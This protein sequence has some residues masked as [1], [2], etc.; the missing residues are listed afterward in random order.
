MVELRKKILT[1]GDSFSLED[2]IKEANT[3]ETVN[4]QLEEFT[5]RKP[6][7]EIN[8]LE[9]KKVLRGSCSRCGSDKHTSDKKCPARNIKCI[10]CGYIGHFREQCRTTK[11]RK[12]HKEN[13]ENKEQ[14]AKRGSSNKKDN[15]EDKE[16]ID[17]IFHIDDDEII[18][19]TIGGV[20]TTML[21]DSG[22]KY[23]LLTDNTW[24]RLKKERIVVSNQEKNPKRIFMAYGSTTP[25]KINR[26][27]QADITIGK[28][29][30]ATFY[31]IHGG[32]K[33]YWEKILQFR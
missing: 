13:S 30:Y 27:F 23:N 3:L 8:R 11:K 9:T 33:T 12:W 5:E 1:A 16:E 14:K 32:T 26:S 18:N 24:E 21:I 28:K 19:C 17:Y 7:N 15:K 31:V 20:H 25:L 22:S 10:K 2:I 29:S 6:L 4:R